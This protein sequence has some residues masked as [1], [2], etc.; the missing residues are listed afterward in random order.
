MRYSPQ[1][2]SDE[3]FDAWIP[4]LM[5]WLRELHAEGILCGCGLTLV[6]TTND[7][8]EAIALAHPMSDIGTHEIF[9]G[10]SSGPT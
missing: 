4:K 5:V 8:I 6:K 9:L 2:G 3:E 7:R 10:I 1:T